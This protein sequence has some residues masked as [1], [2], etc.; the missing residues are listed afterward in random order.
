MLNKDA[1]LAELYAVFFSHANL[2]EASDDLVDLIAGIAVVWYSQFNPS[3]T[4]G[5][6]TAIV[7][8]REQYLF[9]KPFSSSRRLAFRGVT[10]LR[11]GSSVF[12]VRGEGM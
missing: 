9:R 2:F 5:I 12:A 7:S 8:F 11:G 10:T 1:I 3:Q 4:V 6:Q